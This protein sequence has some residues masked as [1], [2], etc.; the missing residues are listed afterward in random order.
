MINDIVHRSNFRNAC[1]EIT[2][3]TKN[4]TCTA[5]RSKIDLCSKA[6]GELSVLSRIPNTCIRVNEWSAIHT[7]FRSYIQRRY[8][9]ISHIK[10]DTDKKSGALRTSNPCQSIEKISKFRYRWLGECRYT[11]LL[12]DVTSLADGYTH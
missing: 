10:N 3:A 1:P 9:R 8:K 7:R 11:P 2:L 5:L 4:P 12:L 6:E